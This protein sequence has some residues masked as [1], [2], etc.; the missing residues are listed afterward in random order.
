MGIQIKLV[1]RKFYRRS[2]A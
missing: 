2:P 1:S